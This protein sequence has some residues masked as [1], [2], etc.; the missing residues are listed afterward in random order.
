VLVVVVVVVVRPG[1]GDPAV[2]DMKHQ[3]RWTADSAPVA[4]GVRP[5]QPN[6]G[7]VVG[8]HVMQG[9]PEGPARTLGERPEEAE[10]LVEALVVARDLAAARLVEDR[11]VGKELPRVS[12]SALLNAS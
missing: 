4:F 9:G 2:P 12:T 11:G 7:L 1:L 6:D 10:Y 3:H 8:H 5:V